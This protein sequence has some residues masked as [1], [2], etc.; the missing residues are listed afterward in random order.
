M[1]MPAHVFEP[2]S[3]FA[4]E[5]ATVLQLRLSDL[6]GD[7][8]RDAARDDE[9]GVALHAEHVLPAEHV[10]PAEP[11]PLAEPVPPAEPALPAEHRPYAEP[12]LRADADQVSSGADAA[13]EHD[14][15]VELAVPTTLPVALGPLAKPLLVEYLLPPADLVPPAVPVLP[16]EPEEAFAGEDE[17]DDEETGS[18]ESDESDEPKESEV[19]A[20]SAQS[21]EASITT[22][23]A[24]NADPSPH[25]GEALGWWARGVIPVGW[26]R[27]RSCGHAVVTRGACCAVCLQQERQE[28][29]GYCEEC[30]RGLTPEEAEEAD[31]CVSLCFTC[32]RRRF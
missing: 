21:S 24:M 29:L 11:V 31:D 18:D 28:E 12:G 23:A 9:Q 2:V 20:E 3:E 19:E 4:Y 5:P 25:P 15:E 26:W 27:C 1:L 7:A 22:D 6:L 13:M 10:P 14:T 8:V 16:A 30:D 17:D 32:A